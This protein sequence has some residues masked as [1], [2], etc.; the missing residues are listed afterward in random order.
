MIVVNLEDF[1]D[2][3]VSK[4]DVVPG[5]EPAAVLHDDILQEIEDQIDFTNSTIVIQIER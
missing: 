1:I 2:F 5:S 3:L 4:K